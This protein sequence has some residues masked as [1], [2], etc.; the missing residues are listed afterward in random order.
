MPGYIMYSFLVCILL[1]LTRWML[2]ATDV[3]FTQKV[4]SQREQFTR[5]SE[6]QL[7]FGQ[8]PLLQIDGLELVQSQAIIRYLARRAELQG[9]IVFCF[10][11]YSYF[12]LELFLC[13]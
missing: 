13:Y 7:P 10:P 2:A 4:I 11:T 3:P 12:Y 9:I 1:N 8:L 6:A 5:M